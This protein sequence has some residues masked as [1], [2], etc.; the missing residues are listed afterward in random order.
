MQT[1]KVTQTLET[2]ARG[3]RKPDLRADEPVLFHTMPP[4]WLTRPRAAGS[5]CSPC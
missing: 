1:K 2:I 5:T 4:V 3:S